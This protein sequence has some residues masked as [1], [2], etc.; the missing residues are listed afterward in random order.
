M[1]IVD[2]DVAIYRRHADER[3]DFNTMLACVAHDLGRGVKAHR[4]GIEQRAGKDRGIMA[5]EPG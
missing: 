4:L 1:T 2:D 5:F 3:S